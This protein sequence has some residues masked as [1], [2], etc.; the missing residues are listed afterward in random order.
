MKDLSPITDAGSFS[1]NIRLLLLVAAVVMFIPEPSS[2]GLLTSSELRKLGFSGVYRGT[3]TGRVNYRVNN[4]PPFGPDQ[5][6]LVNRTLTERI[7][8]RRSSR[9]PGPLGLVGVGRST[10][11][12]TQFPAQG[13]SR[14]VTIRGTYS[15]SSTSTLYPYRMV[16]SGVKRI[17]IVKQGKQNP[18]YVMKTI[19]SLTERR[20][21]GPVYTTFRGS[22]SLEK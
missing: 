3:V 1:R 10:F 4:P 21:D 7:P 15:G 9:V 6:R 20:S 22:A 2:A 16:G 14:R 5:V 18:R 11:T 17:T 19:F 13:N 12:L 8:A